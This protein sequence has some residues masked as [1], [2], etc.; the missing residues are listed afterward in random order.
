[1]SVVGQSEQISTPPVYTVCSTLLVRV[2]CLRRLDLNNPATS[3]AVK[4]LLDQSITQVTEIRRLGRGQSIGSR[5]DKFQ[6][7]P[8]SSFR[9]FVLESTVQ[10]QITAKARVT[11]ICRGIQNLGRGGIEFLAH[12]Y[13]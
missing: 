1:M 13:F 7:A 10:L 5:C 4:K 6:R 9:G 3:E 8:A 12:V 2:V 11:R